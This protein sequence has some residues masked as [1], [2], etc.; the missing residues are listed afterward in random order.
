MRKIFIIFTF[1]FLTFNIEA[2]N[3]SV[4]LILQNLQKI[5]PDYF[6]K[7]AFKNL[8]E[9]LFTEAERNIKIAILLESDSIKKS[10]NYYYA[11]VTGFALGKYPESRKMALLAVEYNP[12]FCKSYIL[13]A[14]LYAGSKSICPEEFDCGSAVFWVAAD[15]L[16]KA[17]T[18]DCSCNE[19]ANKLI[20]I[21][22]DRFPETRCFSALREGYKYTVGCWIN[23]E[24]I[25]RFK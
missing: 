7:K 9:R 16:E 11:A 13:I 18:V 21:Y 14:K 25:V 1:L 6:K 22:E 2:Q 23:E 5:S 24:T 19:E 4:E 17:K 15:K 8:K 10:E 12:K 20:K 3:D